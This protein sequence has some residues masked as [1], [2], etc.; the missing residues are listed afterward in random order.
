VYIV[1]LILR[2]KKICH[3][4]NIISVLSPWLLKKKEKKKEEVKSVGSKIEHILSVYRRFDVDPD[5]RM[6]ASDKMDADPAINQSINSNHLRT[7]AY[8]MRAA[9]TSRSQLLQPSAQLCCI[10]FIRKCPSP[11][12]RSGNFKLETLNTEQK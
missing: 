7:K 10:F 1:L 6:H 11:Q 12:L 2:K 3:K 9:L 8:R 4:I 5:P